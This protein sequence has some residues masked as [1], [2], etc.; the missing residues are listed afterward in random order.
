MYTHVIKYP[1]RI[2]GLTA[3]TSVEISLQ[4]YGQRCQNSIR[5]PTD[6]ESLKAVFVSLN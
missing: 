6:V 2:C 5:G 4:G 3:S 1:P